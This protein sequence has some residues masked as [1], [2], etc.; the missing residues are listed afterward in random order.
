MEDRIGAE[1]LRYIGAA[2]GGRMDGSERRADVRGEGGVR[3]AVAQQR[4]PHRVL[5]ILHREDARFVVPGEDARRRGSDD[6]A[7][8]L[9]PLTLIAVAGDG[10]LPK[11]GDAQP[12]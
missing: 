4:L 12:R 6:G 3:T 1:A 11:L 10:R 8:C 9:Q 7:G 2:R 5:E